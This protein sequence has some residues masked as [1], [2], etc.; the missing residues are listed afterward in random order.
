V[1]RIWVQENTDLFLVTS[2]TAARYVRRFSPN[3]RVAVVPT[4][5][6]AP[7]YDPP[8]QEE[9]RANLGVP[10]DARCVLL[11]SGS[12]GLGPLA[13]GAKALAD[14][15]VWVLAVAGRNEKLARDLKALSLRSPRVVP[16]GF[17]DRIPEL[18]AAADLVVTSSGDTCTEARVIG[19]DI[20]LFDVVP[21]HG[22][23]NLQ[24]ELELGRA[25]VTNAD[26]ASLT[27]SAMMCLDR[28]KPPS[29]RV[30]GSPEAWERAFSDAL[31]Q[32]GL[33]AS[34]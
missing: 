33:G 32:V 13:E 3:A 10:V 26:A 14:A 24:A 34:W 17:T 21:G 4:P 18:M 22:R 7:F 8:T 12:W 23:D 9:A 30:A 15:G 16:F 31:T 1:H 11:M 6:R 27:R 20:L 29:V 25:E 5:V 19:R 2:Q 28:V